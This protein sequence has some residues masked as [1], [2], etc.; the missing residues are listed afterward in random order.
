MVVYPIRI[1]DLVS[2]CDTCGNFFSIILEIDLFCIGTTL[3]IGDRH[4]VAAR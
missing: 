2:R 1:P 3:A 4:G